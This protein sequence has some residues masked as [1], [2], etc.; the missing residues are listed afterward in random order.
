MN[1]L[2]RTRS[3]P[4]SE[5]TV[6]GHLTEEGE[7][8]TTTWLSVSPQYFR[9]MDIT[10]MG[11]RDF[12]TSD[13]ADAPPVVMVNQRFVDQFFDGQDPVGRR[14]TIQEQSR[15]IV[16]MVH[17]IAQTR[18]TG[19]TPRAPSVYFP[20]AQ[21]PTRRLRLVARAAA[22]PVQL[23]GPIQNAVWAVDSEQP[24]A[25]VQT[26][27][28]YIERQ[29]AGPNLMT[30][31]LYA[32]GF[33]AL[34]LAAIGIYGVMAY[35]VSQ[36]TNEIGIRMALGA[37]PRDVLTRVSKQGL[38]LA[39]AC[40]LM[41][42]PLATVLT[43]LINKMGEAA[44]SEGLGGITGVAVGPMVAVGA[45]LAGVGVIACYLPARRATKID[46]IVALQQE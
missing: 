46:P 17:N 12:R 30:Q 35:S 13:R 34:A 8:P 39:G 25:A 16:G 14:I 36:Q 27:D 45:V 15:E 10:L 5:F 3:I 43:R 2:P 1:V 6:D 24:I 40:L 44:S 31:V 20:L 32:V 26:I 41:G 28:E 4:T 33:L 18:L 37:K 23:T 22:D 7:E 42:I 38:M 11:G 29:L 9:T 21:R 19:I